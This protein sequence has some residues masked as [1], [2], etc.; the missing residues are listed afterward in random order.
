[1][2]A[3]LR[4]DANSPE[5]CLRPVDVRHEALLLRVEVRDLRR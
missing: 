4:A 1:L 3:A 5:Q 2:R